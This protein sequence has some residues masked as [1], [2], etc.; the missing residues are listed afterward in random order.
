MRRGFGRGRGSEVFDDEG[1]CGDAVRNKCR[2]PGLRTGSAPGDSAARLSAESRIAQGYV[3]TLDW[4]FA[5]S[6]CRE[7]ATRG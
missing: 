1:A 6:R 5:P 7:V 3:I 2:Q 4:V